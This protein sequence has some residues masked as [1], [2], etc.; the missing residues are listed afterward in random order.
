MMNTYLLFGGNLDHPPYG[1]ARDLIGCYE[2]VAEA[3]YACS[4]NL[5]TTNARCWSEIVEVNKFG[6]TTILELSADEFEKIPRGVV[7]NYVRIAPEK[8][9]RNFK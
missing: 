4:Q 6:F 2:T 9:W 5:A 3:L 1:G 8:G 7:W